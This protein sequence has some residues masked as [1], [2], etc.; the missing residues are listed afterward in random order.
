MFKT[1]NIF[2]DAFTQII[3]FLPLLPVIMIFLRKIYSNDVLNFLMILCL[4]NFIEGLIFSISHTLNINEV[5]IQNIFSLPE[6]IIL[7]QIF[8]STI[9]RKSREV[10]YILL[11][12]FISAVITYYFIKGTGERRAEL[13][14]VQDGIIIVITIA[15]L[16]N[17]VRNNYLH[18]FKSPLFWIA[19]GTLFYFIIAVLLE[20]VDKCCLQ[21]GQLP[22]GD[23]MILLNIASIVRY[24]FYTLASL[25]YNNPRYNKNNF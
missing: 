21:P 12:A 17:L 23:N 22:G 10:L 7:I 5:S 18:I 11:I 20:V 25:F 6:L 9:P 1:G 2:I 4:L 8:K 14:D 3:I 15:G 19:A 24:L 16:L 13:S